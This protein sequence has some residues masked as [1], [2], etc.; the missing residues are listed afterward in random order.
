[1]NLACFNFLSLSNNG[2]V[3]DFLA[4]YI[5][6]QICMIFLLVMHKKIISACLK[7]GFISYFNIILKKYMYILIFRRLFFKFLL[8]FVRDPF[9]FMISI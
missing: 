4:C 5:L 8:V 3:P 1:M 9:H 2:R 7:N 6:V